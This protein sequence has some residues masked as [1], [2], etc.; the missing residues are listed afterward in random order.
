[1]LFTVDVG[2]SHTVSGLYEGPRLVHSWRLQSHQDRTAD[3]LALRYYGLLAMH[4]LD[5]TAVD[6]FILASVVPTLESAWLA[7]ARSRF[8]GLARP[9]LAVHNDLRL[10][11]GIRMEHPEEVGAD[12]LVNAVAAWEEVHAP[13]IVIDFGTAITFDCVGVD[14]TGGPVY[15]GGT[16]HP[17]I[18]ISLDALAG[19]TAKL[20][21]PDINATPE[22][23]IGTSTVKAIHSGMLYGFGGLI[24][25]M[26]AVLGRELVPEGPPPHA[27]AT[28]GMARLIRP[29]SERIEAIDDDLTLKG[30]KLIF[31]RN[32]ESAK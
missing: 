30:L 32:A 21:R 22:R 23:A 12:R 15:R 29:Y 13:L 5:F 25:R 14:E 26:V 27:I 1:M 9:P 8:S 18:G 16:I 2:N 28:G 10:G 19:R 17:G 24:D 3:E 20:P 6:G 7:F 11:M 31:E 4:G